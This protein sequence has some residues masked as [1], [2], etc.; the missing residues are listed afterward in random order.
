MRD[1]FGNCT[2]LRKINLS[3]FNT[4]NV[5]DMW[6]MFCGCNNLSILDLSNFDTSNVTNTN[7]MF[8]Y[9]YALN[10]LDLSHS[11]LNKI[12]DIAGMF[13]QCNVQSITTTQ[14]VKDKILS[15]YENIPSNPTWNIVN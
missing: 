5:T 4:T 1:M 10:T 13:W 6:H 8:A 3:S 9:C 7:H 14:E 15:L 11:N 12:S 2:N